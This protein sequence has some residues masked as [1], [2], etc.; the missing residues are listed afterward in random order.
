[1]KTT[2]KET[3]VKKGESVN[4]LTEIMAL[5]LRESKNKNEYLFGTA[6]ESQDVDSTF[7]VLGFFNKT[8]KN[9]NEPDI[10]IYEAVAEGDELGESIIALWTNTSKN[11]NIYAS[12]KDNE[13]KKVVAFFGK[14]E[15]N[16]CP[17][18][19]IYYSEEV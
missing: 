18:I 17:Y 6:K 3:E 19:R 15:E 9:E 12:G 7:P 16:K 4:Q 1:M 5:W 2:N 10:R 11:G 13:D 14:K 8:K